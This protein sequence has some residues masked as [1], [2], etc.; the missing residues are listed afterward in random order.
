WPRCGDDELGVGGI[1]ILL[2]G[3]DDRRF[4]GSRELGV[5]RN[6]RA[7]AADEERL[8]SAVPFGDGGA[9]EVDPE[10]WRDVRDTGRTGVD[11]RE[12][13]GEERVVVAFW[14]GH[15]VLSVVGRIGR[16]GIAIA[17]GG[18]GGRVGALLPWRVAASR[19]ALDL[20]LAAGG[21]RGKGEER[22]G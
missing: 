21:E 5:D 16:L 6:R 8:A 12:R 17:R 14:R 22:A 2:H 18:L 13:L 10:H 20:A 19:C 4:V 1:E 3:R 9:V 7:V 11:R 15:R